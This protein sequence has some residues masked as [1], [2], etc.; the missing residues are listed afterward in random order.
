MRCSFPGCSGRRASRGL[1]D[2]HYRRELRHGRADTDRI[3]QDK[4]YILARFIESVVVDNETGCILWARSC[5]SN[6]Y[7]Q[8]KCAGK[9][10]KA[11]RFSYTAAMGVIPPGLTID[12][13]CRVRRCVNPLHLEAVTMEENWARRPREAVCA[14]GHQRIPGTRRCGEC[15]KTARQ[16]RRLRNGNATQTTA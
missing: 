5:F 3:R 1:C 2:K 11:H 4:Y 13:L 16:R 15:S 8:F 10:W 14:R 7:G 9:N 12:H 6:G